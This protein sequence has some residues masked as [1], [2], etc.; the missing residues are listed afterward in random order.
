MEGRVRR[1]IRRPART[2]P[3]AFGLP[4]EDD[5]GRTDPLLSGVSNPVT[6]YRPDVAAVTAAPTR[7]VVAVGVQSGENVTGR[8]TAA[9]ADALGLP[10]TEFPGH[11]GGFLGNEYGP[12]GEPEAFAERLREVLEN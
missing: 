5:G 12:G 6:A 10:L 1:H 11:H 9:T 3:A 7:V 4:T 2:R 8:T